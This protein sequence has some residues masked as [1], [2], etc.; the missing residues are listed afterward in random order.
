VEAALHCQIEKPGHKLTEKEID[1]ENLEAILHG[2]I[3]RREKQLQKTADENKQLENA[4]QKKDRNFAILEFEFQELR[5]CIQES[6]SEK[7]KLE[8]SLRNER[9][10]YELLLHTN[11]TVED[12]LYSMYI[13][14][15]QELQERNGAIGEL[16][17]S[18]H[19]QYEELLSNLCNSY[20]GYRYLCLVRVPVIIYVFFATATD[21]YWPCVTGNHRA[22]LVGVTERAVARN[23]VVRF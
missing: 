3:E 22:F 20:R 5:E 8:S 19:R 12:T 7:K 13:G 23:S 14:H 21:C 1:N 16:E 2:R 15:R 18:L 9:K 17:A 6:D 4:L 10:F 11:Q